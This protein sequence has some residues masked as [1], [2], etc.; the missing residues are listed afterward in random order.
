MVSDER[1][2]RSARLNQP[3][4]GLVAAGELLLAAAAVI[5]GVLCWHRGVT[6]MV[7][8]LGPGQPPLVSTIFYA[9]WMASAIGLV[10]VAAVLVLDAVRQA[11]LAIRTR[12]R[13]PPPMYGPYQRI[14]S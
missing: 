3:W 5:V 10:L 2:G 6:T 4:R 13:T 9:D 8:P 14:P 12:R 1:R 11:L 7:T